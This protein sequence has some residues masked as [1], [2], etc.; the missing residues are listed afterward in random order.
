MIADTNA[1]SFYTRLSLWF[2]E[3][4]WGEQA[5]KRKNEAGVFQEGS[6]VKACSPQLI[7]GILI[8]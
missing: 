7:S 1:F 5:P 6:G 2:N 4:V 3:V 8:H